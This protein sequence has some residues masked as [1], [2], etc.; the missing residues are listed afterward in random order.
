MVAAPAHLRAMLVD[1]PSEDAA[2]IFPFSLVAGGP[3]KL[4]KIHGWQKIAVVVNQH[5]RVAA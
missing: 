4:R 3:I 1:V 5:A 2:L